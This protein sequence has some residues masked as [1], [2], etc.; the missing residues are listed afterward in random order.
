MSYNRNSNPEDAWDFVP[1]CRYLPQCHLLRTPG[2]CDRCDYTN[3]DLLHDE[4]GEP[5]GIPDR[6]QYPAG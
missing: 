6:P 2:G 5:F 4:D 3:P 1:V